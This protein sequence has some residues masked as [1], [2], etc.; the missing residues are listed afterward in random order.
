[1][2]KNGK[3]IVALLLAFAMLLSMAACGKQPAAAEP[4]TTQPGQEVQMQAPAE[5]TVTPE[6]T[7]APA[8]TEKAPEASEEA[9]PETTAPKAPQG[10]SQDKPTGSQRTQGSNPTPPKVEEDRDSMEQIVQLLE[11][12]TPGGTGLTDDQISNM[13]DESLSKLVTDLLEKTDNQPSVTPGTQAPEEFPELDMEEGKEGYDENGAMELPFDQLYP[14]VVAQEQVEFD[15]E[16]LLIKMANSYGGAI[17][18]GM[19][20]AGVA[21]ME[22]IVPMAEA[23][24]YEAKLVKGTNVASAVDALRSL[25]EIMLVDYNYQVE[26]AG[27]AEFEALPEG[28]ADNT[29]VT[30]QWYLNYCGIP[31]GVGELSLPGGSSSVIVAV[32]DTG[33]DYTHEDLADNIWVN[34]AETPDNGIDDDGN[35]YIDDYYGVDIVAGTGSG[36]DDNGHGTHVAGIIAAKNNNLGVVGIA[37]NVKIMP[38]K[39]AMASGYLNQSDI[40]KAILYAY[41]HGAEVINM[42]FGGAACSI[43][44]QDALAT[45]YTRCVLVASAGNEG[46]PNESRVPSLPNYPAALSY[47]LGVMSVNQAGRESG[48][49]NWDVELYSPYEYELYAPGEGILSTIPGNRYASWSGTSMA[50]P[51][52][53]AMAAL[54]RSEYTDRDTYPTKFIY[55]QLVAT[56]EDCAVCLNPN[57]HKE[58]NLPPVVNLYKALTVMPKPDVGLQDY[59]LFDTEGM[60]MDTAGVNSGEG[61]IDAGETIALGLTL[62]NRWGMSKDTI[63]KI[64][65]LSSAGIADPYITI[66]NPEVNYGSVGTYSTGNCGAIYTDGLLTGWEN[67]FYITIA[68][69]CPNDYIFRLNVTVTCG[70]ALD[71]GDTAAYQSESSIELM[72]RNGTVLPQYIEEDMVL[73]ADNLYIIPNSTVI[74][75]GVTVRVEPGTHIQFW[76]NEA[77]DPYADNYIAYLQ[78]RGNFLVEGTK[79]NPVYMYPSDLMWDYAVDIFEEDTGYISLKYADITNLYTK[80]NGDHGLASRLISYAEH[81]TFRGTGSYPLYRYVNGTTVYTNSNMN[82]VCFG[83]AK[84]CVFYQ[85]RCVLNGRFE[86]C[87]FADVANYGVAHAYDDYRYSVF[88]DCVFLGNNIDILNGDGISYGDG[89]I[90]NETGSLELWSLHLQKLASKNFHTYYREETGTTYLLVYFNSGYGGDGHIRLLPEFIRRM[91]GEYAAVE[92]PEELNWLRES[93]L[94]DHDVYVGIRYDFSRDCYVWANGEPIGSFV[95]EKTALDSLGRKAEFSFNPESGLYSWENLVKNTYYQLFEFPGEVLPTEITLPKYEI[96][97]DMETDYPLNPMTKPAQVLPELLTYE[98][99]D[100]A[101][102]TVNAS[103]VITP[104]GLGTADVYLRSRD[105][106]CANYITVH[107]V[108]KVALESLNFANDR[109]E[110]AIGEAMALNLT[111]VPANATCLDGVRFSSSDPS[112]VSVTPNGVVTGVSSGIATITAEVNG[113]TV[114]TNVTAYRKAESVEIEEIALTMLASDS[115]VPPEV[116]VNEGGEAM[117]VWESLDE[118][119]AT[120]SEGVILPVRQGTTTIRVTDCRS[121]LSDSFLLYVS[122]EAL[123]TVVDLQLYNI[124]STMFCVLF[125]D[126]KLYKWGQTAMNVPPQLV[127]ENVKVFFAGADDLLI[128]HEDNSFRY[129]DNVYGFESAVYDSLAGVDVVKVSAWGNS[130]YALTAEGLVYGWPLNSSEDYGQF[131]MPVDA[132]M[133]GNP[134]L[135]P[136]ENVTDVVAGEK[137]AVFLTGEGKLYVAGGSN[138]QAREMT[139]LAE[140]VSYVTCNYSQ[141][142][143]V[144]NGVHGFLRFD[145]YVPSYDAYGGLDA[146]DRLF[147]G[148]DS[149]TSGTGT[150]DGQLYSWAFANGELWEKAVPGMKNP[151]HFVSIKTI[152]VGGPEPME[153]NIFAAMENGLVYGYGNNAAGQLG[154]GTM[155]SYAYESV[156]IPVHR[157]E[158]DSITLTGT[159]LT[160]EGVLMEDALVLD[161]SKVLLYGGYT[162]SYDGEAMLTTMTTDEEKLIITADSGF[163]EGITYTLTVTPDDILGMNATTLAEE[164]TVTFTYDPT[165]APAAPVVH[166]STLDTSVDRDWT[167]EEAY[168][169]MMA[170]MEETQFH[171]LFHGNVLL[172]R[173]STV[174]DVTKW[175]RITSYTTSEY[176]EVPLGG[177]WWGSTN[178]TAIGL[179]LV[180][181]SDFTTYARFMYTPY[182]T[183]PPENTF[184]FI[185]D[186]SIFN[187]YGEKVTEVS[188]EE[189]T[190][191]VTFNRD[192]DTSIPLVVRF[193][194]AYPYG[195]YEIDG[196]YVNART[197][198]GSYTLSTLIENGNQCF[199]IADGCSATEDL[200]FIID[201]GR[202]G[203]V[204]DTTAAQALIMQGSATDTGIQLTWTQDD[205]D[206]LMG[207]N[208]YRSTSEDGY[209]QR[210]NETVI[211]AETMEFFDDTVEPGV[212]YYYNFTVV[213][214]DLSES[215]PSGK[216]SIMSKDTMAPDLYHSPVYNA[217]TGANLVISA[218]VTDNLSVTNALV[219]YRTVGQTEWKTAVMNKLNDKYS[220]IIPADQITT[221][222]LEYYIEA[223]DGINVTRKG[224]AEDPY[225][226]TVQQAVDASSRGDV[227]GDGKIT[228]LDALMLLQAINDLLNLDAEQFARADLNGDGVLTAAEALRI[229]HY[230]S[231][232]VGDL[233]MP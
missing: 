38:V 128:L 211:P 207:Y 76:S 136:I 155:D 48:F 36:N 60:E 40:A 198:E 23:A 192:M 70:N 233:N 143:F 32:I 22:P 229:L 190:V 150:K 176:E 156:V 85:L 112:V 217:F 87:L 230:V 172:N 173:T 189:I 53:A 174:T 187:A 212:V 81:C 148:F 120:I 111:A 56:S 71:E 141:L 153:A 37:H 113:M 105:G 45:A 27:M 9:V 140:N 5:E 16:T 122:E 65:T 134:T 163:Q 54:L 228:N 106:A 204:I 11:K 124:N 131:G 123:P 4:E 133:V 177:N 227:N 35:G 8:Q 46:M 84:D 49:T 226:I 62:R 171:P 132:S 221:E 75:E 107:V 129:L 158:G 30:E 103:G 12:V 222:G 149:S 19:K 160:E 138:L 224:S 90:Y 213:Q 164:V 203:F 95:P 79:E 175:M 183:T 34:T 96:T 7:S 139:L 55:G 206:T 188:N 63:V 231:G 80:A 205:F 147:I 202:F 144:S 13:D 166:E 194:S 43:A 179:Q 91:G 1:M 118:N 170:L 114:E 100:T 110:V 152:C 47:V 3:R 180:D 182:L 52:V 74:Q 199:S 219:Y 102:V 51:V 209:Y 135:L 210:L 94:A 125:S 86:R 61:V 108:E 195:D 92:T 154:A 41:E 193:G 89:Q 109:N 214:T 142:R 21:A 116:A 42:S 18:Q 72:V 28:W 225:V 121:G 88:E 197:W 165:A 220:A 184:P 14:D 69:N 44:V 6:E 115:L 15:K 20:D 99:S 157:F 196:T 58:H 31:S 186:V 33:V 82:H 178:E 57:E 161:F 97:L 232:K 185:T 130:L 137:I 77:D 151:A 162:I 73:T 39:A 169:D 64:D 181:G 29:Q 17:T 208:V 223:S 216:I 101:V 127:D 145:G 93:E 119:V 66:H 168:N 26:T 78:V 59:A 25:S 146:Y 159:N 218:T 104:V 24:W 215:I 10:S 200:D 2:C 50:A 117:L 68:E 201:W 98:S 167:G 191:R 126:G 83:V 67:P